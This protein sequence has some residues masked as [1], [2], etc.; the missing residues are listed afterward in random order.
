MIPD[1]RAIPGIVGHVFSD[2]PG[3]VDWEHG[4]D[5]LILWDGIRFMPGSVAQGARVIP[6]FLGGSGIDCDQDSQ[7]GELGFIDGPGNFRFPGHAPEPSLVAGGC[8]TDQV[9]DVSWE[10]VAGSRQA[11]GRFA[12]T[13]MDESGEVIS[14]QVFGDP[15]MFQD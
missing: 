10:Q 7:V 9:R 14:R 13:L 4:K 12:G 3:V 5:S 1:S 15:G 11:D 6:G 8:Q 2:L